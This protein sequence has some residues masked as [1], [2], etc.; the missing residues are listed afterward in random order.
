MKI[1]LC[2]FLSASFFTCHK[3]TDE[4]IAPY[5]EASYKV[6]I[7]MNWAA[8]KFGVPAGAHFTA[9]AGMVH[10]KDASLWMPGTLATPGLEDVAEIGNNTKIDAESDAVISKNKALSKFTIA[11]PSVT[12]SVETN[13]HFNTNHSYISFASMIAPSPDWFIGIHDFNLLNGTIWINDI[14]VN[15]LGYDAG[16]E[17][18]D[19]FNLNNPATVPQQNIALLTPANASVLANGNSSIAPI[20][21]IRFIKN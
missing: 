19:V 9:L 18:G 8:T 15:L 11:P 2:F 14:T 20:G 3:N 10:S 13:L 5:S 4:V 6:I 7:T 1:A 21:T 17:E 16:T 12:G